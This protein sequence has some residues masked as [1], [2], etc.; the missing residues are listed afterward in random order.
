MNQQVKS[1]TFLTDQLQSVKKYNETMIL[2]TVGT[3]DIK[4]LGMNWTKNMQE[5]LNEKY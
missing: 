3:K 2:H 4:C 1:A 5:H